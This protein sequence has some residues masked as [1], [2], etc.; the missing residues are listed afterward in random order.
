MRWIFLVLAGF[1]LV[2]CQS[3][4]Q[5]VAPPSISTSIVVLPVQAKAGSIKLSG[6]YAPRGDWESAIEDHLTSA[7][8]DALK[9][10]GIGVSAPSLAVPKEVSLR[11]EMVLP[12]ANAFR[13]LPTADS[14]DEWSVGALPLSDQIVLLTV[15]ETELKTGGHQ[16]AQIGLGLSFANPRL[17][18]RGDTVTY[19]A[20]V[21]GDTG[22]LIW[23]AQ[24][25]GG[26]ARTPENAAALAARLA[27]L[28]QGQTP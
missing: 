3:Q 9:A 1:G 12:Q 23:T 20:L 5:P 15:H 16:I 2:A 4:P 10:L 22:T 6:E 19:L 11:A 24:L 13:E 14:A 8:I 25:S 28:L 18:E 17:P 27:P 7:L 26:D 21:E